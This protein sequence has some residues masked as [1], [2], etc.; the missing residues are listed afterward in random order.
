MPQKQVGKE[1]LYFS[2]FQIVVHY[3]RKS[4]QEFKESR[5]LEI[6]ADAEALEGC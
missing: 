1:R 4:G 5:N 2:Y 3:Q 6:G